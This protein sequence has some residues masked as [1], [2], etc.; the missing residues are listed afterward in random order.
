MRC[1]FFTLAGSGQAG[2]AADSVL[3]PARAP[4]RGDVQPQAGGIRPREDAAGD[5][6]RLMKHRTCLFSVDFVLVTTAVQHREAPRRLSEG[7]YT[8]DF[9]VLAPLACCF[10]ASLY[11]VIDSGC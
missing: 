2:A 7:S 9:D 1:F 3:L 5:A 6:K 8:L 10:P 11:G 4:P